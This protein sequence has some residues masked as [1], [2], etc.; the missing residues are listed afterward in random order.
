[1]KILRKDEKGQ[2]LV[3]VVLVTVALLGFAGLAIDGGNI[4]L[5]RRRT[6]AAADTAS[7]SGALAILRGYG[8]GQ[9]QHV[10]F[11]KAADNGYSDNPPRTEVEVNWPPVSPHPYAGNYDY[12]QVIISNQLDT[13]FA[14]V[15]YNGP[16]KHTV[17]AVAHVS[18]D[19]DLMP[20]YAVYGDNPSACPAVEF[21]GNPDTVVTG[22]G[23]I[24]SNSIADCSCGSNGGAGVTRGSGSVTVH[25]PLG[26]A[27]I[28]SVGCWSEYGSSFTSVPA[29]Q[30]GAGQETVYPPPSPDCSGLPDRRGEGDK[31]INGTA[32]LTPGRYDSFWF[33]SS[34]ANVTLEK[35]IYCLEG[36]IDG[37][38]DV[39]AFQMDAG[40]TIIGIDVMIYFTDTAGGLRTAGTANI[41]L[42]SGD[43]SGP[44]I[45]ELI[46]ASAE[47]WRG[48]LLY[49]HP[50]N[51]NE[52]HLTGASGSSYTGTIY[53]IGSHC[54]VQGSGGVLALN[55]QM[56][57]DT[58][59]I[60]G[61]GNLSIDYNP[62]RNYK[63]E[64]RIELFN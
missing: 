50:D 53:A 34:H 54:T 60:T 58:V 48:M 22:G 30:G 37:I 10:A 13:F 33:T 35:G 61:G 12:I 5:D 43:P 39:L 38:S 3:I 20:G 44:T 14:H 52:V 57:C 62:A 64:D 26:H 28:F 29:P 56:I 31:M 21:D 46:D 7:M 27:G 32:T 19:D 8:P 17:E 23:S 2:V 36:Q 63:A 49:A 55:T 25:D 1:M 16:F 42:A 9:V 24:L 6:Q 18:M 15:V 51:S 41:N 45:P 59:R 40:V 47:D 4:F 11:N